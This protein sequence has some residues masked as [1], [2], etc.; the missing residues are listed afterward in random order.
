[1]SSNNK[2]K[3]RKYSKILPIIMFGAG[4]SAAFS[5]TSPK[6][7]SSLKKGAQPVT[8]VVSD[9]QSVRH[10]SESDYYEKIERLHVLKKDDIFYLIRVMDQDFEDKRMVIPVSGRYWSSVNEV[11]DI[12]NN[13]FKSEGKDSI[14]VSGVAKAQPVIGYVTIENLS[15]PEPSNPKVIMS[16]VK[17]VERTKNEIEKSAPELASVLDQRIKSLNDK[18]DHINERV[19]A[20]ENKSLFDDRRISRIESRIDSLQSVLDSLPDEYEI[21]GELTARI[22]RREEESKKRVEKLARAPVRKIRFDV[23]ASESNT[24]FEFETG[25]I[26]SFIIGGAIEN[27]SISLTTSEYLFGMGVATPRIQFDAS[28]VST[29]HERK[30]PVNYKPLMLKDSKYS[31]TLR[32][33]RT[34]IK[35]DIG[36]GRS[37][38][39]G[40]WWFEP[41]VSYYLPISYPYNPEGSKASVSGSVFY[42]RIGV[43]AGTEFENFKD[44]EVT[45]FVG[46]TVSF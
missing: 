45:P 29:V 15:K 31:F 14:T 44:V 13:F 43:T 38:S 39:G 28:V 10:D 24:S 26:F 19:S 30:D 9:S 21:A 40:Q 2:F 46:F 5:Q 12:L 23:H 17:S 20:L 11:V 27:D 16:E 42:R 32:H 34:R 4:V 22:L 8:S 18:L 3:T 6:I 35:L 25:N 37:V 41:E 1:M 7:E 36:L 33:V